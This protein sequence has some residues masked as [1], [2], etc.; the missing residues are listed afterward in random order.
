MEDAAGNVT[1]GRYNSEVRHGASQMPRRRAPPAD[2]RFRSRLPGGPMPTPPLQPPGAQPPGDRPGSRPGGGRRACPRVPGPPLPDPDAVRL[3][4]VPDSA[5][6]YDDELLPRPAR[7]AG[8]HR[9]AVSPAHPAAQADSGNQPGGQDQPGRQD[10]GDGQNQGAGQHP[11][12][13]RNQASGRE[14]AGRP[15]PAR[16]SARRGRRRLARPVRAG[17]GGNARRVAAATP[18][19]D[20]DHRA[21][22]GPDPAPGPDARRRP[23]AAVA[24]RGGVPARVR[25]DRDDRGGELRPRVRA[26]A[27]RLE[28]S[29]PPGP[30]PVISPG[31]P[32]GC[33]PRSRRPRRATRP[34]VARS[35]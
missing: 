32:G 26:L 29:P 12:G 27:V 18:D 35:R 2:P 9:P 20:L 6:P 31:K 1:A 5:P 34:A 33:A 23:A 7:P 25:R 24:P 11:P 21:C 30:C 28:H 10:R 19:D 15:R 3:C 17:A 4:P 22:P 8:P 16:R 13:G 14:R